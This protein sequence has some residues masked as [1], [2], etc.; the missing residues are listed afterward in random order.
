[1]FKCSKSI[2]M[3]TLDSLEDWETFKHG[4]DEFVNV[5]NGSTL[6]K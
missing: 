3:I 6:M 1:M 5:L 4:T 2:K